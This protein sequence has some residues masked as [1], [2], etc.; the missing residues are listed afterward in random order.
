MKDVLQHLPNRE[1]LRHRD[2]LFPR[3]RRCLISNS[4]R[5]LNTPLNG[6]IAYG[7]FRCL[8]LNA[9]PYAFEGDYVLEFSS[10]IWE[11]I[12]VLLLTAR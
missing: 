8:D 12:R 11:E 10:P 9:P 5:K 3:Y 6:D 1:I 7:D 2:E 4:Y